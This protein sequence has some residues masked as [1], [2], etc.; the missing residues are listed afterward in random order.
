MRIYDVPTVCTVV[1]WQ[2]TIRMTVM[3]RSSASLTAHALPAI[4][5]KRP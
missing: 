4:R 5:D 3:V 1:Y 2:A